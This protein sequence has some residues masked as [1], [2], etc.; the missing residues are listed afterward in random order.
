MVAGTEETSAGVAV[1]FASGEVDTA[2]CG[3]SVEVCG[4]DGV[5]ENCAGDGSGGEAMA[6]L[7]S[8]STTPSKR[9]TYWPVSLHRFVSWIPCWVGSLYSPVNSSRPR[10]AKLREMDPIVAPD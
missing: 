7:S 3:E 2:F 8:S 10:P 1:D 9:R 5:E 4:V 6:G